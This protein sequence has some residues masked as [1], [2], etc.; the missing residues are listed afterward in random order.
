MKIKK[1]KMLKVNI[2]FLLIFLT[3]TGDFL[4]R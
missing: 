2:Y 1:N 3:K 4:Y